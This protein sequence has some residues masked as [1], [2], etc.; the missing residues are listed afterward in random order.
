MTE[1]DIIA[2]LQE[3]KRNALARY[4]NFHVSA[5]LEAEDGAYYEGFNIES[6]SYG[7]TICAERVALFKALT[8]GAQ[9]FKK[10]YVMSDGDKPCS[11]CGGCRQ[12]LMDY[13]PNITVTMLSG[14]G[15]K[16]ESP[17]R[18]LLPYAFD[19]TSLGK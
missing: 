16:M 11:P 10:I 17:L 5:I 19:D 15:N 1:A 12:V 7:L 14:N 18:D 8:E 13:A 2:R 9:R 3:I 6:S 4:S